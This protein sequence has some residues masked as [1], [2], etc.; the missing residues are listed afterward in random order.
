MMKIIGGGGTAIEIL[1]VE[2][3]PGDVQLTQ[4]AFRTADSSVYLLVALDGVEAMARLRREGP[5]ADARRPDLILLDLNLPNMD[6]REVLA[7]IKA[8]ESLKT[9]PIVMLTVSDAEADISKS[10][11]LHANC[12][13]TK[14]VQLKAFEH[15]VRSINDFCLSKVELPRRKPGAWQRRQSG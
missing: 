4:K 6:G 8:D 12:Y 2:D 3:N 1:L 9:I 15:L 14:P 11:E 13:L 5:Y 10:Y 7:Q